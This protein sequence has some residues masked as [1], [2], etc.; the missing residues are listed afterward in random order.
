MT[1]IL[2]NR[3]IIVTGGTGTLGTAVVKLLLERGATVATTFRD[4]N[5]QTKLVSTLGESLTPQLTFFETDV[6]NSEAVAMLVQD[7][8]KK[9]GKIDGLANLVGTWASAP[10]L[11]MTPEQ[12]RNMFATNL[13]TAFIMTHAVLPHMVHAGF[14][15]IVAIGAQ[16]AEQAAPNAAHYNASKIALMTLMETVAHEMKSLDITANSVMP[17][18]ITAIRGKGV[19]PEE[20]AELIAYLMS[21]ESS[22]TSGA[23]IPVFGRG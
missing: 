12:W 9:H 17:T 8:F 15:R 7:V 13:T 3:F 10:F 14:G 6:T 21:P 16:A 1:K 23:R 18:S 4:P 20:I 2:E 11:E 19:T 22:G 5:E